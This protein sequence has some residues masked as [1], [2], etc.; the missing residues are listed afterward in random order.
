MK[1]QTLPLSDLLAHRDGERL[2]PEVAAQIEADEDAR[3]TL[4][5]LREIKHQLGEL[6]ALRPPAELWATIESRAAAP[7]RRWR[8]SA[9]LATAAA[10]F[11]GVA[12]TVVVLNPLKSTDDADGLLVDPAQE[13]Q[14]NPL[15]ELRNES[16]RL[17]SLV[18]FAS[19]IGRDDSAQWALVYRIADIDQELTRLS[20]GDVPDNARLAE[21]W[22]QRVALLASLMEVQ[23]GEA[24]LRT[25]IY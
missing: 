12:L 23:R 9:Q 25:A 7:Q 5:I 17:E 1:K 16:Q 11:L 19:P 13:A 3:A 22:R 8:L 10:V 20:G 24:S 6:E 18:S 4:K 14:F 21:L 2:D 15:P